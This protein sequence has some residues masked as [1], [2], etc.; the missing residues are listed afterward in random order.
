MSHA[1]LLPQTHTVI[2]SLQQRGFTVQQAEAVVETINDIDLS[3]LSTKQDISN[4]EHKLHAV[5]K[6][7]RFETVK[8]MVGLLLVNM[9]ATAGLIIT[10]VPHLV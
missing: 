4:T 6:Q 8:W 10:L 9:F 7:S 1:I 2:A 3:A 5:I